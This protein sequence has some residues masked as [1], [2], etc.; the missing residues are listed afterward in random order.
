MTI[1]SYTVLT[2]DDSPKD[3]QVYR[4]YLSEDKAHVYSFLEAE[5]G[6]QGLTLMQDNDIDLILLDYDLPDLNGLEWLDELSDVNQL[7]Q[8]P[9][10]FLTCHGDEIIAV[11]AIKSGAAD[12]LVK[13]RLTPDLL[14]RTVLHALE[15]K[16][17]E[18]ELL[19][20]LSLTETLLD[21][22]PNPI[23][24]KN[25]KG[26]YM[27]C[28]RAYESITGL[29]K[30]DIIGR[31]TFDI[32]SEEL[33]RRHHEKDLDLFASPGIQTYESPFQFADGT[34][35]N[36]M[37]Y[38][39][40]F[41][42]NQG[43]TGGLVGVMLD[44]TQRKQMEDDLKEA[45]A[46]LEWNM[47]ELEK[48]NR[49]IID[50]Q[51]TVIKEERLKVLLQM[52]GAMAHEL[53]QPLMVL[54]G[55]VQLLSMC[56]GRPER[57][58]NHIA[59]I[60]EAGERIADIVRKIQTLRHDDIKPY[61]GISTIIN[62]DQVVT[63]LYVENNLDDVEQVDQIL[64][65]MGQMRLNHAADIPA[66]FEILK[67]EKVDL[68]LLDFL[69]PSGTA[70]DFF[71]EM[72]RH[73]IDRP[74]VVITGQGDDMIAPK[75]LQA[76]AY[77]YLL[78]SELSP[79]TLPR[80]LANA[81]EKS[82]LKKEVRQAVEKMSEI[83]TRDE[84]TGLYN[85]RFMN[86]VLSQEFSRAKRYQSELSCMILDLDFFKQVN[87]TMGPA[88]G[89]FLLREFALDM[90]DKVRE[91]DYC[92]RY[93][94]EEFMILLPNT[95]ITGAH[96]T[97]EKIRKHFETK[98]YQDK[99]QS[100]TVSVSIGVASLNRH[101]PTDPMT[102]LAYAD[103]AL[104]KAK[105]DGRNRVRVYMDHREEDI[106][107]APGEQE[108]NI[109]YLKEQLSSILEKTKSSS[110]A[111][112]ELLVG[113]MG[114]KRLEDHNRLIMN[115]MEMLCD[116]LSLPPSIADTFKRAAV[117]HDCF[118][119]LLPDSLLEKSTPLD[120]HEKTMIRDHPYMLAELTQLFDFFGNERSILLH[121]HEKYDG[122]GY[123]EGLERDQIP[124]GARIFSIIDAFVA[125]TSERPYRESLSEK[126]AIEELV[127]CSGTQFDPALISL[128]IEL[129]T[130]RAEKSGSR[131]SVDPPPK[132]L[133]RQDG[134]GAA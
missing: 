68:I 107:G 92:F 40:T 81:L 17:A 86:D 123:P 88:F 27:G 19:D 63:V 94:G 26:V 38:K 1:S 42:D 134:T 100:A 69:L 49:Q 9:V 110:I 53:N 116:R 41:K 98:I 111:A 13:G 8:Y 120:A 73:K 118:M 133:T 104:Y 76:G 83:S 77:D 34:L 15:R 72:Q 57:M 105:S 10:I 75:V 12:Y 115:L 33:A 56:E 29:K 43:N 130:E 70:L 21:T 85:R 14:I 11:E 7:I 84:L 6:E 74:V 99:D 97:A 31:T 67:K 129:I 80:A 102:L 37:F 30:E 3:R 23:F 87:D 25:T 46:R 119:I 58:A 35:H 24:Y 52:A 117:L 60:E 128:F 90:M 39:A 112:I 122:S 50:Q 32:A 5:T 51:K 89:D 64:K 101:H 114:A 96:R 4:Q 109:A 36:V 54:L 126:N 18:N 132:R 55:N 78:K 48:A 47:K 2:I 103:K 45:K 71:M 79:E 62:L 131:I 16:R 65:S 44:I 61:A 121:H 108:K 124:L 59:R 93:G 20:Y 95:D 127:R 82:R 106:M 22:I 91:S 28:N 113:Q 125:M 66:A